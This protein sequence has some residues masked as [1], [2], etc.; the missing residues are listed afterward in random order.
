MSKKFDIVLWGA[1]GYTGQLIA[2][3]LAQHADDTVQWAIA[4][5][6]QDKLE[7]VRAALTVPNLP[8]LIGDS[9]DQASL[10][11]IVAQTR[12]ICTTVGPYT[13]YGTPLLA[14][15]AA[16]G[17]DYCDLS[18]EPLWMRQNIDAYHA[19]AQATGA[20]IVHCCGY[21]S[22]PSD[23]GT[24]LLQEHAQAIYGRYCSEVQMVMWAASGG[25]SGGTI[26]SLMGT[27]NQTQN[28]KAKAH[29]LANPFNLVPEREAD[30]SHADQLG[31]RYDEELQVWTMP[32]L[33]ANINTRIVRRSNALLGHR[34]GKDFYYNESMRVSN[35]I[36]AMGGSA[37]F[38]LGLDAL[39]VPAIHKFVKEKLP[40]SGEGPSAKTRENG[41]FKVKLVGKIPR[42]NQNQ[43]AVTLIGEIADSL[44]PGYGS[45]SK[46]LSESALCLAFDDIPQRGGILTP[47]SA[48]GMPLIQRLRQAG[49][50][51]KP[52]TKNQ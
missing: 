16:Q 15:C 27:L 12:V 21:D 50:V 32:F 37:L 20:R 24:F 8:I 40:G 11:A 23:L 39:S 9:H 30:W 49:M 6:N 47:A 5:R 1:T 35:R 43:Q 14:T 10:D 41:F 3:Y 13:L 2:K 25:F 28:D 42:N 44:D 45:T 38:K 29:L 7:K 36:T 18:G 17:V 52:E 22:I 51:F 19:L 26:T 48:M 4:G 33:M 31:A 46:M 34:Y